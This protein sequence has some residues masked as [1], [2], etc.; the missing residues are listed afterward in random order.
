M[1]ETRGHDTTH[2]YVGRE[3]GGRSYNELLLNSKNLPHNPLINSGAIM[4]AALL[5]PE[6]P[7]AEVR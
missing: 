2:R 6:L 4:V 7:S 3:P 1:L 5:K